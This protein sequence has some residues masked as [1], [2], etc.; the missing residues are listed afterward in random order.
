MARSPVIGAV[1]FGRGVSYPGTVALCT[2]SSLPRSDGP[3]KHRT[4]GPQ[5]GGG[6][7]PGVGRG[8]DC[9]GALAGR[10]RDL[11]RRTFRS[12]ESACRH[13]L[14]AMAD[15]ATAGRPDLLLGRR[16]RKRGVVGASARPLRSV[17]P[18]G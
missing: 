10:K 8:P 3:R 6:L 12:A 15:L 17:A 7:L 5:S 9:V 14:D 2:A 18:D 16:L 13:A 4:S 1:S 11:P